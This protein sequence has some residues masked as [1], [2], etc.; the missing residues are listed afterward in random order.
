[1]DQV[2]R[3]AVRKKERGGGRGEGRGR[4]GGRGKGKEDTH[5]FAIN[6]R[7]GHNQISGPS[8][9]DSRGVPTRNQKIQKNVTDPRFGKIISVVVLE[10]H[11]FGH[12]VFVL[13]SPTKK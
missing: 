10:G 9:E 1:V 12:Q 5:H 3:T 8:Q 11:E 13:G 4:D 7:M 2:K 6:P